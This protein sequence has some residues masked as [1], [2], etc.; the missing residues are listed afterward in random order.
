MHVCEM[1]CWRMMLWDTVTCSFGLSDIETS[2][3]T[4]LWVWLFFLYT[5]W[6]NKIIIRNC[7]VNLQVEL[8]STFSI[9]FSN[10]TENIEYRSAIFLSYYIISSILRLWSFWKFL[11]Y[12]L[13]N[14]SGLICEIWLV[15]HLQGAVYP[16]IILVL[17]HVKTLHASILYSTSIYQEDESWFMKTI[18]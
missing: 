12:F 15:G 1:L 16:K 4:E 9:W 13:I 2:V 6:I 17:F 18:E 7:I 3:P 10:F 11:A 14:L 5:K 8:I